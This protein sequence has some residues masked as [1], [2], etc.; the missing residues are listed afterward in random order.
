MGCGQ[1]RA[2][3]ASLS[4][5]TILTA[6]RFAEMCGVVLRIVRC[7]ALCDTLAASMTSR[8]ERGIT[9]EGSIRGEGEL[10]VAGRLRGALT[11]AGRLIVEPGGI[12]EADVEA[13][14]IEVA[15]LLA[16]SATA[17][18]T[19]QVREGGRVEARIK[20][21]RL[22]VDDGAL[23]RGELMAQGSNPAAPAIGLAAPAAALAA[24]APSKGALPAPSGPRVR[25][26]TRNPLQRAEER[27]QPQRAE[28]RPQPQRSEERPQQAH[29]PRESRGPARVAPAFRAPEPPSAKAQPA[30]APSTGPRKNE[31]APVAMPM[32]PRGRSKIR[33]RGGES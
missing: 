18:N 7:R 22:M 32:L 13:T 24:P 11:L 6:V 3:G 19:V 5:F 8:I 10:E 2:R 28:E 29:D 17:H 16:G 27:P 12:V 20:A 15:G 33:V 31:P 25:E 21:Q 9:I 4:G 14:D 30:R 23:F 1:Y 26:S